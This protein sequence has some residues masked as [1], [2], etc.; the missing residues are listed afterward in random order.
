MRLKEL[1]ICNFRG[2]KDRTSISFEDC[3]TAITGRNDAGKST[4]L[5]ALEIFF[6]NKNVKIDVGDKNVKTANTD[7]EITCIFDELPTKL[8]VDEN[9]PTSFKK[10]YLVN[11]NDEIEIRKL[12]KIQKTVSGPSVHLKCLH[13]SAEKLNNLHNLKLGDLKKIG[14]ELGIQDRVADK[15]VASLWREA[16]WGSVENLLLQE[17]YL[18]VSSLEK[19]S[20]DIYKK[21]EAELPTFALFKSDRES[22]DADPEAKNPMQVAVDQAK[23]ALQAEIDA[24]QDKIEKSVLEVAE[25]TKEKLREMDPALASELQPRF[26]EKPKWT[27]SFTL[28][29]EDGVPINKRGS[30]VRRLILLNFFRAEAEK[31]K[32]ENSSPRVIYAIEEPETSQHP[33]Y[34]IMLIEALILLSCRP[35]CQ[36]ILTTH[37]PALAG[38][39]PLNSI[40]FIEKDSTGNPCI[41]F[42]GDDVLEK[43]A[44]SLGVLP[45]REIAASKAVI[46]VEGH[47]DVTFLNHAATVLKNNGDIEKTLHELGIACIPIG[48]CGNLKHWVSKKLIEQLDLNWGILIDSDVGDEMQ[49][50]RNV[51]NIAQLK[52]EGR[53]AFSTRKREPENYLDP[54]LFIDSHQ[55]NIAYTDTCDAKKIIATA[56][57]IRKDDVLERFWPRMTADQVKA[58]STYNENGVDIIEIK[59]ILNAFASLTQ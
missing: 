16:L 21:I 59:E 55:T 35:D 42:G 6:N 29:G 36:I 47:S 11:S 45:E 17:Q 44:Q 56:L 1:V 15:R 8:I 33:S 10:E 12:Y 14:Q 38:L 30:G 4:I 23:R 50:T 51:E 46:L 27:F 7:I 58:R 54:Q 34:Q 26:K 3:L 5:E 53:I 32:A 19:E 9:Y 25:R 2:Y 48:G 40:R 52:K 22:N 41:Q 43:V 49:H 28:D 18:D 20:K 37:V 13:P 31:V 57:T 24:L 39:L